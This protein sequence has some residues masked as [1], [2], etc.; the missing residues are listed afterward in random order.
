MS[1]L[2]TLMKIMNNV[3]NH[4][5]DGSVAFGQNRKDDIVRIETERHGAKSRSVHKIDST[6]GSSK[7][8]QDSFNWKA[9]YSWSPSL[10][11]SIMIL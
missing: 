4:M 1:I 11:S 5:P 7:N 6:A 10:L 8:T 9:F 2:K 3:S